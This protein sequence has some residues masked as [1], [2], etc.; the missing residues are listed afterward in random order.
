MS[1]SNIHFQMDIDTNLIK[2]HGL[3]GPYSIAWKVWSHPAA[4]IG[5]T[6]SF[7]IEVL[8]SIDAAAALADRATYKSDPVGRLS[9]TMSYFL[10]IIFGDTET[11]R[12]ANLRLFKL[13]SHVKGSIPLTGKSYSAHDP[14]LVVGTHLIT[15]HSVYYAYEKLVG[16]L[17]LE[18]E[19][20]Y[21][22]ESVRYLECL[23]EVYPDLSIETVKES[24]L[25]HGYNL[26]SLQNITRLPETRE[27]FSR[28][29]QLTN[30]K[31]V[32][33]QQTR[34]IIN[35]L[36][37]P[38]TIDTDDKAMRLVLKFY[39]VLKTIVVALTPKEI[40]D[41][42]GLSRSP[43]KDNLAILLGKAYVRIASTGTVKTFFESKIGT[44]G[45]ALM[46]NAMSKE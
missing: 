10:T 31:A 22:K 11:V 39:P 44:N 41:L 24:A 36:L 32:I 38:S 14:L 2:D 8:G 30:S 9:R 21:F 29:I 33:T 26:E 19:N 4:F 45:Y 15:W 1:D 7:Y 25:S 40:C 18:E 6:R 20:Q 5:L 43:K 28:Y 35:T 23:K 17:S 16:K 37:D 27:E 34:A 12:K 42:A 13:H 3:F 46:N